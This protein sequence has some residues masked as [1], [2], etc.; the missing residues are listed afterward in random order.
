MQDHNDP[1]EKEN[2][3][4]TL[5][6]TG[7]ALAA[8]ASP[9][10]AAGPDLVPGPS[11][12]SSD[13]TTTIVPACAITATTRPITVSVGLNGGAVTGA[14]LDEGGS[15]TVTCNTPS[16]VISLGSDDMKNTTGAQIVETDVFTDT[17]SF[18]GGARPSSSSSTD[19]WR[20]A[21]RPSNSWGAWQ[22]APISANTPN[23]RQI[24]LGI[25]AIDFQ[26]LDKK[27][28]AGAYVGRICV[29]VSPGGVT[30]PA[31]APPGTPLYGPG[32]G[33]CS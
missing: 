10:L 22:R 15:V 8:V 1:M 7:I 17:I 19:G 29:T 9:A 28:T 13:V 31:D 25:S 20:L 33:T 27:P 6:W 12:S 14:D 2:D 5:I 23:L 11:S 18:T 24:T 4:K 26:T 32:T 21:S 3:M 16:G 30:L